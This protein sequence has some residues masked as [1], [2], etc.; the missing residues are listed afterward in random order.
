MK[1]SA[2]EDEKKVNQ[3]GGGDTGRS[4]SD[5]LYRFI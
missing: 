1:Y 4:A 3:G 5:V 2:K